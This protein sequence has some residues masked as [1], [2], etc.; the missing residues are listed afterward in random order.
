M[1][2]NTFKYKVVIVTGGANGIAPN[3]TSRTNNQQRF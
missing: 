1:T 2:E 3:E